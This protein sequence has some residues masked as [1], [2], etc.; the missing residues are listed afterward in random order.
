[1]TLAHSHPFPEPVL[2]TCM[3]Q[4]PLFTF[5]FAGELCEPAH[6]GPAAAVGVFKLLTAT[7]M[8]FANPHPSTELP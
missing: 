1:M 6:H 5:F 4:L 8:G 2:A 7:V 3:T